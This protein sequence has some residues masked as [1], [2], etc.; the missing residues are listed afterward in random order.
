[1]D[2]PSSQSDSQ[3]ESGPF[4]FKDLFSGDKGS[5]FAALHTTRLGEEFGLLLR[6]YFRQQTVQPLRALLRWLIFGLAGAVF[7]LSGL[8][9]LALAGL[10]AIQSETG[11][12]FTGNLSWLP[13]LIT[14]GGLLLL[15]LVAAL[16]MS[17]KPSGLP[18]EQR[19]EQRKS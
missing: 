14:T 18:K 9:M 19:K 3:S 10:R 4:S 5:P 17:K 13:Y 2:S 12:T 6:E 16:A 1:M 8:A 7:L 11:S 15:M